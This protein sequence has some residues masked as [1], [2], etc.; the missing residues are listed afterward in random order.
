[1]NENRPCSFR[2]N[3]DFGIRQIKIFRLYAQIYQIY[4]TNLNG[5]T[6]KIREIIAR[7]HGDDAGSLKIWWTENNGR[8]YVLYTTANGFN[9]RNYC[10]D[11][12]K[13]NVKIT[14]AVS[15]WKAHSSCNY[16]HLC[17]FLRHGYNNLFYVIVNPPLHFTLFET[18]KI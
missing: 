14:C 9:N 7:W 16:P 17:L 10:P 8:K 18:T 13:Q 2:K 3:C 6:K 5:K 11:K 15:K 1:M 12:E 4:H